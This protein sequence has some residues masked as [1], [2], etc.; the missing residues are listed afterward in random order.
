MAL[1]SAVRFKI[2]FYLVLVPL[3]LLLYPTLQTYRAQ[4][5]AQDE[6]V[7]VAYLNDAARNPATPR[8]LPWPYRGLTPQGAQVRMREELALLQSEHASLHARRLLGPLGMTAALA[9]ALLG[10]GIVLKISRDSRAARRS[11]DVLLNRYE[12][13]RQQVSRLIVLHVVL[14]LVALLA[15]VAYECI[16]AKSN[17]Y[18]HGFMSIL[19]TLPLWGAIYVAVKLLISACHQLGP[20]DPIALTILGRAQSRTQ[21]L[22][23]WAWID[24]IAARADAPT[25]DHIVIGLTD[26]FYVTS[27]LVTTHPQGEE[28]QGRTLYLP[29]P[30]MFALSQNE[31]AAIV[32]H[33]LGHFAHGDTDHGVHLGMITRRM[34]RK[35]ERLIEQDAVDGHW[36]NR[37][38]LWAS[39]YFYES[40]DGAALHW[41][42]V[43]EFAADGVGARVAG[44]EVCAQSLLRVTALADVFGTPDP[45][46]GIAS[47]NHVDTLLTQV[48]HLGLP[49]GPDVLDHVITHPIDTH[50]PTRLRIDALNVQID[51][52]FM[53]QA[54]RRPDSHDTA[55]FMQLLTPHST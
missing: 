5:V 16:W 42:R 41:S 22:G 32:G 36:M 7:I 40:F 4:A 17:W 3:L 26:C 44:A 39:I 37:P 33:E 47:T 25:P 51:A 49:I 10:I 48:R 20:I 2:I 14:L 35:I 23:L 46:T 8:A 24:Q 30:Y 54:Q 15:C 19:M 52:A 6:A 45:A 9:A 29:L 27:A 28:L 31:T 18:T 12:R 34:M 43:K 53:A 38:P 55:W 11:L 50:P 1:F 21:A 13:N